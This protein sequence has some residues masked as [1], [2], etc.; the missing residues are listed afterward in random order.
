MSYSVIELP[1]DRE[2]VASSQQE[3]EEDERDPRVVLSF[4]EACTAFDEL[5][6]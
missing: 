5:R 3:E 1:N 4:T 6:V 2:G